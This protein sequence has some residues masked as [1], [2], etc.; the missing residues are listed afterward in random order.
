MEKCV[1]YSTGCPAC[2]QLKAMLDKN[3]IPYD[4]VN[5]VDEIIKVLEVVGTDT[6]PVLLTSDK[7]LTYP[8]AKSWIE[9]ENG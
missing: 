1:L 5:D 6:V 9:E 4:E 8:E 7:L 2:M 3:G